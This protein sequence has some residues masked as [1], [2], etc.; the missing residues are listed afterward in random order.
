MRHLLIPID[1]LEQRAVPGMPT[2]VL[3]R[4]AHRTCG[5]D[6]TVWFWG[7]AIALD[8][9]IDCAELTGDTRAL[10]HA[11][12]A[13][14]PRANWVPGW[15]DHLAPGHAQLRLARLTDD[16]ELL[17]AASALAHW[18]IDVVPH[19]DGAALYRPDQPQYRHTVWVDSIYH[20]P[21]FLIALG[22][23]L[24][25]DELVDAGVGCWVRHVDVLRPAGQ[26]FLCHS[27][28]AGARVRHGYGWARGSGWA[29]LGMADALPLIPAGHPLRGRAEA[30]FRALAA[31]V[32]ERQDAGGLWR[33]LLHDREAY[34]ETSAAAMFGAAFTA[35][36]RA[37]LLGQPYA[38]AAQRAWGALVPYLDDDGSLTGVSACTWAGIANV[39]DDTMYKTLPTETNVWGQGSMLRFAAER[40]RAGLG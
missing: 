2:D 21:A 30:D 37:G 28:D 3:L 6:F 11:A 13:L 35:G 39:N 20:V 32:L 19:V 26:P 7:D 22:L 38:A 4:A 29:L 12:R 14:R 15:I 25:R 40:V 5:Y 10:D 1:E 23:A 18:L 9:L 36:V 34:L 24:E 27:Y 8:G 31:A 16:R 17:A 33:T